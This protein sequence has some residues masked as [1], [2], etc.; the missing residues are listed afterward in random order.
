M[1]VRPRLWHKER[2]EECMKNVDLPKNKPMIKTYIRELEKSLD[3]RQYSGKAEVR[4]KEI[5][6]I[7][8]EKERRMR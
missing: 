3:K 4:A 5:L 8:R 1:A 6:N 2:R 7:A